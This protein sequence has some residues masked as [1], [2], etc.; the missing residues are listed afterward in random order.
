MQNCCDSYT[1]SFDSFLSML[2]YHQEQS[3][4]SQWLHSPVRDLSVEPL[5]PNLIGYAKI[6]E[7]ASGVSKE[8]VLDTANHL[9]LALRVNGE[10]YP[11]RE[12][13]YKS[14]LDGA[15]ISG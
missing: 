13:A 14:L 12:T 1:T 3:R 15:K 9:G 6:C 4:N 2:T 7:F 11:V 5:E 10:L 8:A